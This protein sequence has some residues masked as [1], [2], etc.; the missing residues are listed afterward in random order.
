MGYYSVR[1]LEMQ[2]RWKALPP[3]LKWDIL[4]IAKAKL[5]IKISYYLITI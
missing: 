1:A 5:K 3:K 4:F 2:G